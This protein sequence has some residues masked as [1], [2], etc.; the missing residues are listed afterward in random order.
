MKKLG[1]ELLAGVLL[2]MMLSNCG[3]TSST[4]QLPILG[5]TEYKEVGG[6]IDTVYHTIP[7]FQFVD[8]DSMAVTESTV[9]GKIYV[10]DFFFGTCPTICP[11]MK[12]QMLR[13]Y[14]EFKDDPNF[15]ILSHTIDP[16]HDTVAYLKDFSQRLGVPDNK[17]WHFLTGN[18][19]EIY[20]IGSSAGYLVPVG[21]NSDAPGGYIHSGAFILVDGQRRI[22]GMY[23]GTDP[24]QVTAL[25]SDIP[26]LLAENGN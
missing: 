6:K 9:D 16:E 14:G 21:E 8:Q 10:A 17:T 15:A 1:I 5:R 12:Q 13:V 2:V 7:N 23:D 4:Q 22:R 3:G 19:D 11:I 26:K 20:E 18:K 24:K 25:I